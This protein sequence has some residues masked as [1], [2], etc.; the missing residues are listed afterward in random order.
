MIIH[1]SED[2]K[3]HFLCLLGQSKHNIILYKLECINSFNSSQR[4]PFCV[5]ALFYYKCFFCKRRNRMYQGY[6]TN[7]S[8]IIIKAKLTIRTFNFT[9]IIFR[10]WLVY[11][12]VR[13]LLT[14]SQKSLLAKPS[15][16]P[17]SKEERKGDALKKNVWY[18]ITTLQLN[19]PRGENMTKVGTDIFAVA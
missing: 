2:W 7:K 12:R 17:H 1:L 18:C 10:Q 9:Q 11:L 3:L 5:E 19:K 15:H 8:L 14:F 16:E 13:S 6:D 4:L